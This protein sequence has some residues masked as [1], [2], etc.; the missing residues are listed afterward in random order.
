MSISISLADGEYTV[1]DR[2]TYLGSAVISDPK[3][4]V[5]LRKNMA[6]LNEQSA[7]ALNISLSLPLN[8]EGYIMQVLF[9][10]NSTNKI[11]PN[12]K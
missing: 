1:F 2:I 5:D 6:V 11:V 12:S 8:S 10:K 3:N 4:V 7:K 9:S